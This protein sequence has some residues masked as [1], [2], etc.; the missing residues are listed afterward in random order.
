LG[1]A[2]YGVHWVY[3]GQDGDIYSVYGRG[4]YSLTE[5]SEAGRPPSIPPHFEGHARLIGKIIIGK[6]DA[7]FTSVESAF[8][9]TFVR[10]TGTNH[11]LLI[12]LQGG[13][14]DEYYHLSA[15]EYTIVGNTSGTNTGDQ[16]L[17]V[18]ALKS[19]VLELDN[20]TPYTPTL[21]YHPVTL[22][23]FTDNAGVGT[24]D[25][26][27][28]VYDPTLV[29]GDAF[30]MENMEESANKKILTVAER[31]AISANSAKVGNATHTGDAT[32]ATVLTV[33]GLNGTNLAALDTGILKNTTGT[34][35]PSIAIAGDFPT[36]N[37][38]TTGSAA[39]LTTPRS[40]YGNNFNGS[41]ALT[42]IIASTFG[43]TGNGFTRFTGPATSEKTFTLPNATATILTSA[44][45]VSVAQGGTGRATST[46]AFGILAAGTTATGA[47]QTLP[48]GTTS[49][50]LV[51]G[52]AALPVWTL[53]SGTGAPLRQTLP[54]LV[55]PL[56]G[57]PTSGVLTNCTGLPLASVVGAGTAAAFASSAFATSTQGLLADTALQS[58]DEVIQTVNSQTG[59]VVL[60]ADD[61]SDA[62]TTN[63]FVTAAH[64]TILGNTSG[65]NTGDQTNVSG[66]A[67]NITGLLAIANGG[68]GLSTLGTALHVLRVNAGGTALEYA[69]SAGG[70][71][72]IADNLTTN[73]PA[74]ALAASQGVVIKTALDTKITLL[75]ADTSP[76][77]TGQDDNTWWLDST[78]NTV[79]ALLG[80]AWVLVGGGSGGSGGAPGV[81]YTGATANV[82]LGAYNLTATEVGVGV[83]G[84]KWLD[85]PFGYMKAN[86]PIETDY[87]FE[88]GG[89]IYLG[90]DTFSSGQISWYQGHSIE[91]G[92]GSLYLYSSSGTI[93]MAS[94]LYMS[95]NINMNMY[96]LQYA[97]LVSFWNGM[98][99]YDF[100][101]NNMVIDATTIE[102]SAST[103]CD[104]NTNAIYMSF[105]PTSDPVSPGQLW[106]DTGTVKV[107]L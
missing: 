24:G 21:D 51:G 68:T 77:T 26:L 4:S 78:D 20:T 56:L 72:T 97:N 36:L 22:K 6:G 89:G 69:A 86:A 96:D 46:T 66:T 3:L 50:M 49:Q 103:S 32:G 63:K 17:S 70:G 105:L 27:K 52:G 64:L 29:N 76:S 33:V 25:M 79:S 43:G 35:V 10:E 101:T 30:D 71:V 61:I 38:S 59:N 23:Y 1:N 93:D 73:D 2:K 92:G 88:S 19:N 14:A 12:G 80:G 90:Q 94:S 31:A 7:V 13:L 28:S 104:F 74:Q 44:A 85:G 99:I 95:G 47:H 67:S 82:D 41:A 75:T 106:N 65:T 57:T 53:A 5:A 45:A 48:Q 102:F 15:A 98:S 60:D 40:I 58:G 55:T 16:D 87:G 81:P 39:T 84:N 107:S 11:N 62:A 37:Q 91:S 9:E 34:G 8:Q 42:Q 18:Y 54:T 83:Y 100:G